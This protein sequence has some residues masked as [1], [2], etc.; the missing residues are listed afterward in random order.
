MA[1]QPPGAGPGGPDE[2]DAPASAADGGTHSP[3]DL[4]TRYDEEKDLYHC[5]Y[6]IPSPALT[7]WDHEREIMV[8]LDRD[9]KQVVGF[10]IPE[11]QKWVEKYGDED[12]SFELDLPDTYPIDNPNE[13]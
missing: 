5:S 2:P 1:T 4:F 9:T 3:S 6:G 10:S 7:I 8:R 13:A 12:G 11:F